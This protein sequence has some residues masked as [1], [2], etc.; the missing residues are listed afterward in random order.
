MLQ[1]HCLIVGGAGQL[2]KAVAKEFRK[3]TWLT[4]WQVTSVDF[5]KSKYAQH[6]IVVEKGNL[7]E[8]LHMA[9]EQAKARAEEFDVIVDAAGSARGDG[10]IGDFDIF[11]RVEE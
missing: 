1:R 3:N 10:M 11:E 2:G 9:V 8:E 7:E 6:S 4:R 5:R